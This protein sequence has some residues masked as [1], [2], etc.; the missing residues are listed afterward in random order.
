M[1]FQPKSEKEAEWQLIIEFVERGRFGGNKVEL[2]WL[3]NEEDNGKTD[4]IIKYKDKF[5]PV[6]A[7]RK[8]FPNHSG[9]VC[10]FREGWKTGFLIRDGG[11][12]LNERTIRNYIGKTFIFIVEINGFKPRACIINASRVDELLKQPYREQS[13]TNSHVIQSVKTVPLDWFKEYY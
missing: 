5:I 4:G 11:I 2:I 3:Q 1:S 7:R 6:E 10:S 9:K 13:N 8:G 12:F